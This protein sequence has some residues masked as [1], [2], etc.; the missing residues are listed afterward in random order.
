MRGI[1]N[2]KKEWV[3][4]CS[5]EE[6][7]RRGGSGLGVKKLIG[8]GMKNCLECSLLEFDELSFQFNFDSRYN[9]GRVQFDWFK[10][11]GLNWLQKHHRYY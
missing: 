6:E 8:C 2:E 10:T 11:D 9:S 3:T 5:L 1:K 7:K 4:F